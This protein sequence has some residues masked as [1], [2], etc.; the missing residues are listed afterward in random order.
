MAEKV[1]VI[2]IEVPYDEELEY[3]ID[4]PKDRSPE[5][6]LEIGLSGWHCRIVQDENSGV[7]IREGGRA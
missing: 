3:L 7:S 1:I 2:R 5:V 6:S 4:H